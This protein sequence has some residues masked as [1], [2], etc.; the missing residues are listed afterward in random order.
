M[1]RRN[2]LQGE[3]FRTLLYQILI[4]IRRIVDDHYDHALQLFQ[5]SDTGVVRLQASVP[6]GELKRCTI[7]TAFITHQMFSPTWLS[8]VSPRMIHLADLQKYIFTT[9]YSSP[10]TSAGIFQLSFIHTEGK[11]PILVRLI[12]YADS[13]R[14]YK[15]CKRH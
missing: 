9:E 5:D 4:P 6:S 14:C 3:S 11:A 2:Y 1:G 10:R 7:W 12:V 8:R 15:F 13:I